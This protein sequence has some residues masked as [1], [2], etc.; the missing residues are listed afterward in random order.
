MK[1]RNLA[2]V[3]CAIF[4]LSCSSVDRDTD[5]P[6]VT[7]EARP[8]TRWW[9]MGNAVDKENLTWQLE[10]M[11]KAGIGGVE[12][13]PIYGV[14]GEEKRRI[15]F[16]SPEWMA[17][18]NHTC[19]E[20]KRLGMEVDMNMGTGW[21]FGGPSVSISD[22]ATCAIF[23][24]YMVM[25]GKSLTELLR[26]HDMKQ[27]KI[28]CF[29]RLMAYSPGKNCLDITSRVKPDGT[30][31]WVAPSGNN[32]RLIALFTGKTFQKVKRAAPGGE[33][34]VLDHFSYQAVARYLA[35]FDKVFKEHGTPFPYA[36]F[37]DSYEV[38]GAD[39]TPDFLEQFE[40]RRGY[41]L[42]VY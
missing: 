15:D 26:V 9:W 30:V 3:S 40:R 18:F 5:W 1:I 20:A 31:D 12:I 28:A 32:W 2:I 33:G 25:G 10:E 19:S 35:Y 11:N 36:F 23:Q 27:K 38:Y 22:A 17:V 6:E 34:Y 39:W 7:V 16:L 21:P 13:T 37:N 42:P 29:S 41:K 14:K 24:E 8:W 4:V